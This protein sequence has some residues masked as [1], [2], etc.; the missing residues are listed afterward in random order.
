MVVFGFLG[1][2]TFGIGSIIG[3]YVAYLRFAGTL[4][5]GR[6]LITLSLLLILGGIQILSFGFVAIQ[7]LSLRK[8]M[9]RIQKQNLELK[10]E[11]LSTPTELGKP[12]MTQGTAIGHDK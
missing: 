3:I 6:P 12:G 11:L 10:R 1:V 8:E 2:L 9:L 4:T 7:I 5:P